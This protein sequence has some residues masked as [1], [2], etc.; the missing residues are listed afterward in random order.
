MII[1]KVKPLRSVQFSG[2]VPA[3]G[4]GYQ[5]LDCVPTY[6]T[7]RG[8]GKARQFR[9]GEL[10]AELGI[11]PKTIRYYEQTGLLPVQTRTSSGYRVYGAA[12]Q[13]R[14]RF[15]GKAKAI[16]LSLKE[17]AE[18]RAL[19]DF[20]QKLVAMREEAADT[21]TTEAC[22]CGIIERHVTLFRRAAVGTA[23]GLLS[24]IDSAKN[25]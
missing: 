4:L 23:I 9:I 2:S 13:D 15:I 24:W 25:A 5:V 14:L 8:E 7:V 17:I 19:T 16:G 3:S 22:V 6:A 10:A 12:D 20:K 1:R 18:V 11:D 21:A